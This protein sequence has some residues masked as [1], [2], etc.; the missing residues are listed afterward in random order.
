METNKSIIR[1]LTIFSFTL[2][3]ISLAIMA[4]Y[5]IYVNSRKEYL[6]QRNYRV[7]KRI[8]E[9]IQTKNE[10]LTQNRKSIYQEELIQLE[11]YVESHKD[12]LGVFQKPL[13]DTT[14]Y[15]IEDLRRKHSSFFHFHTL[16][17]KE[18]E[19]S[20]TFFKH[21]NVW[22]VN[23]DKISGIKDSL[24]KVIVS[25]RVDDVMD[26]LARKDVYDELLIFNVKEAKDSL[27][28]HLMYSSLEG[29]FVPYEIQDSLSFFL[30]HQLDVRKRHRLGDVP[31]RIYVQPLDFHDTQLIICGLIGE[32]RFTKEA[33]YISA[34]GVLIISLL[35]AVLLLALSPLRLIFI[36]KNEQLRTSDILFNTVSTILTVSLATMLL[37]DFYSFQRLDRTR[38]YSQLETLA[39]KIEG[40]FVAELCQIVGQLLAYDA[41]E[42]TLEEN[43]SHVAGMSSS[44]EEALKKNLIVNM[45]DSANFSLFPNKYAYFDHIVWVGGG[46]VVQQEWTIRKDPE[47]F[48]KKT[49]EIGSTASGLERAIHKSDIEYIPKVSIKGREY[50]EKIKQGLGWKLLDCD[51]E[52]LIDSSLVVNEEQLAF[53]LES[54]KT[55][56][57]GENLAVVSKKSDK[58]WKGSQSKE[59]KAQIIFL[60]T[61]LYSVIRPVLPVGLGFC[62]IDDKGEVLFH[63]DPG[64][65]LQENFLE[66]CRQPGLASAIRARTEYYTQGQYQGAEHYLYLRSIGNLPLHLVT[67]QNKTFY[68]SIH[69]Q[70]ISLTVI[71]ILLTCIL[72]L[73]YIGVLI[74]FNPGSYILK[75]NSF[76][77]DWLRPNLHQGGKYRVLTIN[78]IVTLTL[79]YFFTINTSIP[80]TMSIIIFS[81]IATF[82]SVFLVLNISRYR[83]FKWEDH[84]RII[85]WVLILLAISNGSL[86]LFLGDSDQS[87]INHV[88]LYEVLIVMVFLIM[89][90]I[91][92]VSKE[93]H[94]KHLSKLFNY[95]N[96]LVS[97]VRKTIKVN[98]P[99]QGDSY[100]WF[101]FSWLLIISVLPTYKYYQIAYNRE[102]KMLLQ[103]THMMLGKQLEERNRWIQKRYR[104]SNVDPQITRELYSKGVYY[105]LFSTDS[106]INNPSNVNLFSSLTHSK[107][108][109]TP[110]IEAF[111][112]FLRPR[113]DQWARTT[114][115]IFQN[116]RIWNWEIEEPAFFTEPR[117][118]HFSYKKDPFANI[119]IISKVPTFSFLTFSSGKK[120][121]LFIILFILGMGVILTTAY[122]LVKFSVDKLFGQKVLQFPTPDAV[123]LRATVRKIKNRHIFLVIPPRV[124]RVDYMDILKHDDDLLPGEPG[125]NVG[126]VHL[127]DWMRQDGPHRNDMIEYIRNSDSEG[128]LDAIIID[129]F[130]E[131]V[132]VKEG[133]LS[134]YEIISELL[135]KGK[136]I[137]IVSTLNPLQISEIYTSLEKAGD[138][139]IKRQEIHRNNVKWSELLSDF[140]KIYYPQEHWGIVHRPF[141]IRELIEGKD[142]FL[143]VPQIFQSRER[144]NGVA[145]E[146]R[147]P[148]EIMQEGNQISLKV[149]NEIV[150]NK[151]IIILDGEDDHIN[152]DQ[153]LDEIAYLRLK[154]DRESILII[155][156][157]SPV[158]IYWKVKSPNQSRSTYSL[159]YKRGI[160]EQAWR[161]LLSYFNKGFFRMDGGQLDRKEFIENVIRLECLRSVYLQEIQHDLIKR[162]RQNLINADDKMNSD[163][164]IL[165]IKSQAQLYYHSLWSSC[166]EDEKFLIYDMANDGVFNSD[167]VD[168]VQSLIRKGIFV[169]TANG[170]SLMNR[171]FQTFILSNVS[172]T[173]TMLKAKKKDG[174]GTWNSIRVPISLT[175]IA[176]AG[177]LFFTQKEIIDQ[178]LAFSAAL[179]AFIPTIRTIAD[180]LRLFSFGKFIPKISLSK[181]K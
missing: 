153:K 139:V 121:I 13:S 63:S 81:F 123:A 162:L 65:N 160:K 130:E 144:I 116:N 93:Y 147:F 2:A 181:K 31:Y 174:S 26:N 9:N 60:S 179:A 156:N 113:Y 73:A 145:E 163:K 173:S 112:T 14:L 29:S 16:G 151:H 115:Q 27:T 90:L 45:L 70:I 40:E 109:S 100:L 95:L 101:V 131:A 104:L 152:M 8:G 171:S 61:Y 143:Q 20:F 96:S 84:G 140:N 39:K 22:H 71:F 38:S 30:D 51:F 169:K 136:Q 78:N 23:Y 19:R 114:N 110:G 126:Y 161:L 37:L 47:L 154:T 62:V 172:L 33:Q 148:L 128:P 142:V 149:Y 133:G 150:T 57:K 42:L 74:L 89:R 99:Y 134:K 1:N 44:S 178:T 7:L 124:I 166:S 50:L 82:T 175:V 103:H 117:K 48:W 167:D 165:M 10:T 105:P 59:E 164:I 177:F 118:L 11:K 137:I 55:R 111:F 49:S 157:L 97:V 25:V 88:H 102:S 54:V 35:I 120:E 5:F 72:S 77:F 36:G 41:K 64:K 80:A 28:S 159:S 135:E 43:D 18:K 106:L 119:Y 6:D 129:Y 158:D 69:E 94:F 4:Y 12:S 66:E 75:R 92:L 127:A 24:A 34:F 122:F 180:N 132:E 3:G 58:S 98:S 67:F 170:I 91:L 107:P 53:V 138:D 86:Y 17:E 79:T 176:L 83:V 108:H 168:A 52:Q 32:E 125:R 56:T 85:I 15:P 146:K 68:R 141:E 46:D 87:E 155:S 21:E 76:V